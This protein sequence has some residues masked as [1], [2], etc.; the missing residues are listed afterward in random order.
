MVRVPLYENTQV[1]AQPIRAEQNIRSTPGAF[2]ADVGQAFQ[3]AGQQ[4]G[5]VASLLDRRAEERGKEDAEL[6]AWNAYTS[7]SAEQQKLFY[8][9]DNAIYNRRGGNSLGVT[10]EAALELRRIGDETGKT[11]TSPHAQQQFQKLWARNQDS[12]MGA[13]SRH[14]AGQRREYADQTVAGAVANST[15]MATLRYNDAKEVDEQIQI[16]ELAIRANTKGLPPEQVNA[17]VTAFQSGVHKAVTLRMATDNPLSAQKYYEQ[18][19]DAFTADDNV[20]LQRA[21]APTVKRATARVESERI[22]N[23]VSKNKSSLP[24]TL[25][26]AVEAVESGGNG[27]AESG[28]GAKGVM[29]VLD[30][31]GKEVAETL[32][33]PWQPELMKGTTAEALAYQRK[34]G[35]AYLDQQHEKYGGN[36]VLALAAYNAGPGMVD[37]WMNGTNKT[38]KNPD[39]V[40]LGDPRTGDITDAAWA[41]KIPFRETRDYV[42]KVQEKIGT[43][44]DNIDMSEAVRLAEERFP[45]DPEMQDAVVQR[46]QQ[47]NNLKE[48]ARRDREN[49]AWRK[50]FDHVHSGGSVDNLPP[51]VLEHLP[52]T[53][54]ADLERL[55][56]ARTKGKD[57]PENPAEFDRL[58]TKSVNDP[59]GFVA[60]DPTKWELPKAQVSQLIGRKA[61]VMTKEAKEEAKAND[62]RKALSLTANLLREAKIDPTP[63]DDKSTDAKIMNAYTAKLMERLEEFKQKE[64]RRATDT[65]VMEMGRELLLPGRLEVDWGFDKDI[66]RFEVT[67]DN[68]AKVTSPSFENIPAPEKTAITKRLGARAT[69][70]LVE[71]IYTA[72]LRGNKAEVERLLQAPAP[73]VT[74]PPPSATVVPVL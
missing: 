25:H 13:V 50:G 19:A 1:K 12:E 63:K 52:A 5:Q 16:G 27:N 2:G 74:P 53:R 29:Q 11:L 67:D 20:T 24:S 3:Q 45:N 71:Q 6:Q 64:G 47:Q 62:V 31:T 48:A 36:T 54:L 55:E 30:S 43:G 33:I 68:R 28:A 56:D 14:E 35:G 59:E 60:E 26:S 17:Q 22:I 9:G 66:R 46:I 18:H 57:K 7:A 51:D 72:V 21:L 23:D 40:K 44:N 65:E 34:I 8:Q 49:E 73:T 32:G 41:A 15:N 4:F 10:N 39:L 61:A 42:R 37:D 70:E 38:G 69:N 58:M